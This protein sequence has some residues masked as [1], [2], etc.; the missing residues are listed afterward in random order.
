MGRKVEVRVAAGQGATGWR[1]VVGHGVATRQ[2]LR[3]RGGDGAGGTGSGGRGHG[4]AGQGGGLGARG[5]GS[6]WG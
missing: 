3:V 5:G 6:W 4:V 1:G 2:R